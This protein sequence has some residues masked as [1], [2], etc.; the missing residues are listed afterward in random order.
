MEKQL[1]EVTKYLY[2]N[3]KSVN[4]SKIFAGLVILTL[5]LSS[6]LITLP[7]S[8]TVESVVK[9]S[10]SQ[11]VLVFAIS[12]M[13]TR[14]VF[15]AAIVTCI[16]AILMEFLFNENSQLCILPEGFVSS[17]LNQLTEEEELSK[18]ELDKA[19]KTIQ[20]AQ[21]MLQEAQTSTMETRK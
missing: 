3:I 7:M 8:K 21:K 17:H 10:F 12:W 5:N 13:G 19:M 1:K 14:D 4:D 16:F 9:N 2:D 11:Y 15:I 20:K 18:D 6:K